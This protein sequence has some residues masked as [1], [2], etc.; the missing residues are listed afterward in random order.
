MSLIKI[1]ET[2]LSLILFMILLLTGDTLT[3]IFFNDS[4]SYAWCFKA[5]ISFLLLV[6]LFFF[7]KKLFIQ[8]SILLA[9][10]FL[11]GVLNY[12]SNFI[13]KISLFF[14]Y[15]SG[16]LIFNYLFLN[17]QR[18]FLD[19]LLFCVFAFYMGTIIVAAIFEIKFLKTY[20][21]YRFGY[22]PFFSSQNEF[23]FM[24]IAIIVYFF[25]TFLNKNSL[26][27]LVLLGFSIISGLLV[28]T[29]AI[30][31][32]ILI[33]ITFLIFK[34][35]KFKK[36]AIVY[37]LIL[38]F[39]F[40]LRNVIF[41]FFDNHFKTLVDVY[42][43]KGILDT[44]LSLRL[45]LLKDR[46]MCQTSDLN[47][48]NYLFGGINLNC[49]TE[50][51]IIDI[52]LFFGVLGSAYYFYLYKTEIYNKL[53]LDNFGNLMI[54]VIVGLSFAGG[55]FFEN[56][57]AQFYVISVLYVYYSKSSNASSDNK[58]MIT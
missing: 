41:M 2:K 34:Y 20:G 37:G 4:I 1:F 25:K 28:G 12:Q 15:I 29:K 47:F 7:K 58:I 39:T 42:R 51:S 3:K 38:V 54:L 43:E 50:M 57:S 5:S 17:N 40:L 26:I 9:I 55:Y 19:K 44:V 16:I 10:I 35:L 14:E 33:F 36:A 21:S 53:N 23:S 46:L 8:L 31:I 24:M 52:L 18:E 30:Y 48:L 6:N 45:S 27:N 22:M 32:F 13:P 49:I 11:V 56:F